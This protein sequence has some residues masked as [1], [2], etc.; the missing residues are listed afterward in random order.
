MFDQRAVQTYAVVEVGDVVGDVAHGLNVTGVVA[1]PHELRLQIQKESPQDCVD[2][3]VSSRNCRIPAIA[4]TADVADQAM[5]VQLF[6]VHG[7]TVS[8]RVQSVVATRLRFS[9]AKCPVKSWTGA[10][11]PSVLRGRLFDACV[12]TAKSSDPYQPK[13][14]PLGKYC[15]TAGGQTGDNR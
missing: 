2:A 13:S 15:L 14:L 10:R 12:P 9:A 7:T 11:Q 1:R 4:F 3:P 8:A 6:L 5:F